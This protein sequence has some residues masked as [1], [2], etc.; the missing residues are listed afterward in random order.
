[1]TLKQLSKLWRTYSESYYKM[2]KARWQLKDAL[3][4]LDKNSNL[5]QDFNT[6]RDLDYNSRKLMDTIV[7]P[8]FGK[9]ARKEA[10]K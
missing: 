9:L 10:E 3:S 2:C 8:T 7:T 5:E 6:A 4:K 1:M